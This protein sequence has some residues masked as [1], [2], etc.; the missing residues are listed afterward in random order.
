MLSHIGVGTFEDQVFAVVRSMD[1]AIAFYP[2][3]HWWPCQCDGLDVYN[4]IFIM[5]FAN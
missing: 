1:E 4:C 5:V 3:Y 2:K